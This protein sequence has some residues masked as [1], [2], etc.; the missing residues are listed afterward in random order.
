MDRQIFSCVD[1]ADGR[2]LWVLVDF[3]ALD[4]QELSK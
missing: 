1:W 2:Q 3:D 4:C